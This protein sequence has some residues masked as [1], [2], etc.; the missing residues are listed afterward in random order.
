MQNYAKNI[1][2][3]EALGVEGVSALMMVEG[4]VDSA[5]FH[6]Y[7]ALV[8]GPTL[9]P[10]DLVVLDNLSLHWVAG[11]TELI[12]SQGRGWN[13]LSRTPPISIQ[14]SSAG[15]SSKPP[16]ARPAPAP[17][18]RLTRRPSGP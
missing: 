18:A 14:L 15:P 6:T 7:V 9:K 2:L 4:T 10:A 11:S 12:E 1:S 3:L 17:A 8:L 13:R 16:S 5:I